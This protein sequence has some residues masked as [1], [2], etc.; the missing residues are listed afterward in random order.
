[1]AEMIRI[2]KRRAWKRNRDWPDGWEPDG[3]A[4]KTTVK[5]TDDIKEARRIC[6]EHNGQRKSQGDQFCEFENA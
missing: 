5:Y 2:F 3:A 4:Q 1:M 6:A